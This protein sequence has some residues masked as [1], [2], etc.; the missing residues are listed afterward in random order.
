MSEDDS[1]HSDPPGPVALS[2][3]DHVN[4]RTERVDAL[5]AFYAEILDLVRGP[6]PPFAFGGA[7]L[8]C[9]DRAVVHLVEVEPGGTGPRAVDPA[10][11]RLSHFAFRATGLAAFL[12][13]LKKSGIQH[14]VGKLPGAPVTQVNLRD[15][16]GNALHVDFTGEG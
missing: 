6:R 1:R 11:L 5:A 2:A 15:I 12:A 8:Y 9:G 4:I 13:R 16:D 3:L 14:A 7:W 10:E